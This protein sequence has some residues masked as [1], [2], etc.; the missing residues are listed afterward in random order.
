MYSIVTISKLEIPTAHINTP[1]MRQKIPQ[2]DI[3]QKNNVE[4]NN[5]SHKTP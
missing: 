1:T 4:K 5:K 3:Q 2:L